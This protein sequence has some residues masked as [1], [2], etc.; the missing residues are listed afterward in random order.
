MTIA[1][2]DATFCQFLGDRRWRDVRQVEAESRY[3]F[4]HSRRAAYAVDCCAATIQNSD[5]FSGEQRFVG[6]NGGER[7]LETG[8]PRYLSIR[9]AQA[10]QMMH[11][12]VHT[13]NVFINEGTRLDLAR[14]FIGDEIFSEGRKSL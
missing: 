3:A 1:H 11:R 4:P 8:T 12:R 13:R 10:F 9:F 6:S 5:H 7:T 2:A 14:R